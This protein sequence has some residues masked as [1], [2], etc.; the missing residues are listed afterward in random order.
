MR[1]DAT[2]PCQEQSMVAMNDKL[3]PC[4]MRQML[5]P[6]TPI[7]TMGAFWDP[8][9]GAGVSRPE[10]DIRTKTSNRKYFPTGCS[11]KGWVKT[12]LGVSEPAQLQSVGVYDGN[13]NN[14]PVRLRKPLLLL[15]AK[16]CGHYMV[17]LN[18]TPIFEWYMTI[19]MSILYFWV[20]TKALRRSWTLYP[21]YVDHYRFNCWHNL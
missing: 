16:I 14:N 20:D 6:A 21:H 10:S 13:V 3:G 17:T 11:Q 7:D 5:L 18:W 1:V 4:P 19:L 9:C 15:E 8:W 12:L 2:S